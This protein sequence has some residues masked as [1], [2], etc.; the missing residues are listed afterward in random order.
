MKS[1]RRGAIVGGFILVLLGL[2]ML[3]A[4]LTHWG[5]WTGWE[6]LWPIFLVGFG[7]LFLVAYFSGGMTDGGL[8]W[9]ATGL[10]LTGAFFFGFTLKPGLWE[11]GQ[12]S[13]LWPVFPL[14]WGFAF[15]VSFFAERRKR[16]DFGA[17]GFGLV[18][19]AFGGIALAYTHGYVGKD[20]V[21]FWP[22]LIVALGVFGLITGVAQA[23]RRK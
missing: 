7:L 23:M 18:A 5:E 14:I 6:N 10:I 4:Q 11:W 17:L 22:L 19:M 3:L 9:L 8:A 15:V 2:L 16:R 13:K 21:R 1:N 20:I 12:M